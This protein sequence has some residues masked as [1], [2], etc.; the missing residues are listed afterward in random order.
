MSPLVAIDL[1]KKES[2]A[3][4]AGASPAREVRLVEFRGLLPEQPA[5]FLSRLT[6]FERRDVYMIL[7]I[8]REVRALLGAARLLHLFLK[9]GPPAAARGRITFREY[10][11]E[12]EE[13]LREIST[14]REKV[15]RAAE[16]VCLLLPRVPQ[17]NIKEVRRDGIA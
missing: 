14:L 11:A 2:Q 9:E 15:N 6:E 7:G 13:I 10:L 16:N 4:S 8:F 12:K 1:P 3:P 17:L 5:G